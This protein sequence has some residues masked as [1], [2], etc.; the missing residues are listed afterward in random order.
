MLYK[1]LNTRHN[2]ISFFLEMGG[3]CK[4]TKKN[5]GYPICWVFK[6]LKILIDRRSI[7]ICMLSGVGTALLKYLTLAS[8]MAVVTVT[9]FWPKKVCN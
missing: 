8:Q 4:W 2:S 1:N 7:R 3:I 6:E 5:R 9:F